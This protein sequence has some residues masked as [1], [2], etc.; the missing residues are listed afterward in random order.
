MTPL[1]GSLDS[2]GMVY[3]GD[4]DIQGDMASK[5][6]GIYCGKKVN[7]FTPLF[8]QICGSIGNIPIAMLRI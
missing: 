3:E 4:E 5:Y 6:V 8:K 1:T 7:L 2:V